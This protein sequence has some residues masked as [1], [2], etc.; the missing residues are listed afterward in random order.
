MPKTCLRHNH[1]VW[2]Q[3]EENLQTKLLEIIQCVI[4][5]L[6]TNVILMYFPLTFLSKNSNLARNCTLRTV[7][8]IKYY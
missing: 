3:K 7:G 2:P 6:L 5:Q 1:P 8:I 4:A